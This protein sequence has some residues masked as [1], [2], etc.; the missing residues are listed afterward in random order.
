VGEEDHSGRSESPTRGLAEVKFFL[1]VSNRGRGGTSEPALCR[2][3]PRGTSAEKS[4]AHRGLR[5]VI[6]AGAYEGGGGE[7]TREQKRPL[8]LKSKTVKKKGATS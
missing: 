3:C 5:L 1:V 8:H 4:E 2:K 7:G 6:E